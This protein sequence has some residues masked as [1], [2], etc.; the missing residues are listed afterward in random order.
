[1][2]AMCGLASLTEQSCSTWRVREPPRFMVPDR[3]LLVCSHS[4]LVLVSL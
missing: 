1:M 2:L 3:G 4:M